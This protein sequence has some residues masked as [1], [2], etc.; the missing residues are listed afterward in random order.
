VQCGTFAPRGVLRQWSAADFCVTFLC[1]G[2]LARFQ[3]LATV[4]NSAPP[5]LGVALMSSPLQSPRRVRLGDFELNLDTAELRNNGNR[6]TIPAQPFQVLLSLLHRPG[7]LVT[8]EELKRQLWT[9]DTFVDFDQSLNKAVNRLREALA[10]SA[11]HPRFIETLPKRGYRFIGPIESVNSSLPGKTGHDNNT[12]AQILHE[13]RPVL[14]RVDVR[15]TSRAQILI[16]CGCVVVLLVLSVHHWRN[17]S[18]SVPRVTAMVRITNDGW[19]KFSLLGDGVRLYFS[20]RGAIFQTSIEGGETTELPTGLTD[21]D[22]YDISPEG[23]ELL[24]GAGVQASETDERPIWIVSLPAGTPRRIGSVK[25]LWASWAPDR[26]HIAYATTNAIYLAERDG[27]DIRKLADAPVAPWKLQFSPDGS[28][29]RFDGYDAR[30]IDSIWEMD[31]RDKQPNRLFPKWNAPQHTG[32]WAADAKYFFFNTHDPVKDRDADVWVLLESLGR[33]SDAAVQLTKGPLAFG[34]TFPSP[35][36]KRVFVVGTQ[37]RAE[38]AR[39]DSGE[40][41][42]L[43]YMAG[44]SASEAEI[45]RDGNWVAYV[46]YPDLTLWRSRLDGTEKVQ[47]TSPPMEVV[48]ARWSPDGSRIAFTDLQAGKI[49]KVYT[50]SAAG[51]IPEQVFPSDTTAEIDPSWWP[52]GKSIV[53]GRS[54]LSGKGEI[55]R[56]NLTTHQASFLPGAEKIFSPRLSP[57][58]TKI[59]AFLEQGSKLMLYDFEI[60]KWRDAA[61]GT[62]EFNSWSREGKSIYLVN[63]AGEKEIVRFDL[64]HGTMVKIASLKGIEQGSRGWVGLDAFDSPLLVRDNSVSDVYRLD[65]EL[66]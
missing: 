17:P 21:V 12:D 46:S 52:D 49:W 11:E 34:Y 19:R 22:L 33:K 45:S 2:E 30:N 31:L 20:E 3:P 54:Y 40:K 8:R 66:P 65:L 5:R 18:S 25:G 29:L 13:K 55:L 35:D 36:G 39:Y 64:D 7:V 24:V 9:A 6:T 10:D 14:S 43:P 15:R 1:R 62:F 58:G 60:G 27:S 47:L 44:I 50:I 4:V 16:V 48:G 28:S 42:F 51:G 32:N 57:D 41:Q 26:K 56:V 59:A 61:H 53:L 38:L 63:V 37:S 23:S